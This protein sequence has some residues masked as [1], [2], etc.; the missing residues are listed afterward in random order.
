MKIGKALSEKKAAQNKLARLL[1]VRSQVFLHDKG[2][3]P[4]M[5]VQELEREIAAATKT[6]RDLKLR[7]IYT[8]CT[9]PLDNEMTLQEAIIRLGDIRSE[10]S[11]YNALLELK[12]EPSD[13]L[14]GLRRQPV[15]DRVAQL[16][17]KDLLARIEGLEAQKYELDALIAKANNTLDLVERLPR[18]GRP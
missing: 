17:K 13:D 2:K 18:V 16:T 11:A 1:S 8:N 7:I 5:T 6:I 3:K 4:D 9:A 12:A 15:R 10:L 14:Y